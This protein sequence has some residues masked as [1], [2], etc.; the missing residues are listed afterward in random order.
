[1]VSGR[2]LDM[3][4]GSGIQAI[5]AA[6]KSEVI[7][8]VAV[9]I[10]SSALI[11]SKKLALESGI[12]DKI[13]FV[14]SD[15]FERVEG[16]FDWILF[17]APYLP[18]EGQID[19]TSWAGGLTGGELV[20]SFLRE[21][22][23]YLSPCGAILMVYSSYSGLEKRDFKAYNFELLEEGNLFFEKIYCVKLTPF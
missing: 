2:V 1:M 12:S 23:N 9:D 10:N 20:R 6:L 16:K 13:T 19:E 11:Y 14:P 22:F 7:M 8:V 15:L 21:A 17:N 18:S 3:G 5:T 4:T